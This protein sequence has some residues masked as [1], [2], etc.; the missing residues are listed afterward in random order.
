LDRLARNV[1]FVSAVMESGVEFTAVDNPHATR[2]TLHILAAVAEHEAAMISER[3]R[4]ALAAAKNRGVKLG[5]PLAT[6]TIAGARASKS[7]KARAKAKNLI[8]IVRDI[9]LAGITSLSGVARALEARGVLTP[10]GC[11]RWQATQVAQLRAMVCDGATVSSQPR[12]HNNG[13]GL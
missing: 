9:E 1:A 5:S 13:N 10:R 4:A 3:T 6:F 7:A 11:S 8:A 12:N 2:L